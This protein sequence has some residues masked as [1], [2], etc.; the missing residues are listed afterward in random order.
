VASVEEEGK[1]KKRKI[2]VLRLLVHDGKEG[3]RHCTA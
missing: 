3:H 1:E 2:T